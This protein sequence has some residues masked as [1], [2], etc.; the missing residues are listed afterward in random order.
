MYLL[1][2]ST[3]VK[4]G[5]AALDIADRQNAYTQSVILRGLHTL[6]R[7]VG[8]EK[9]L[10]RE[11]N[12]FSISHSDVD[13][14]IW[15]HYAVLNR[16]DVK[17]YRHPIRKFDFTELNGKEKWTAYTFILNI[18]DLWLPKHFERI[19][20]IIDM[21]PADLNFDVSEQDPESVSSRS[22]LSQ[23]LESHGLDDEQVVPDNQPSRQ[24]SVQPITPD[25][26]IGTESTKSKKKRMLK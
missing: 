1:F 24:P 22:G 13:V 18:Y 17:Y 7:L 3:E 19:C 8:R 12:G 26:T 23:G 9:E 20:D 6:F 10:H 21:L 11:I 25:T 14:R 16:D 2:F 5:A 15:G 4:C